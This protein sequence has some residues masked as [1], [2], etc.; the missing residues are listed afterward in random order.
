MALALDFGRTTGAQ[1][2]CAFALQLSE[3]IHVLDNEATLQVVLNS[4]SLAEF[5]RHNLSEE[6]ASEMTSLEGQITAGAIQ[7]LQTQDGIIWK[8]N[9]AKTFTVKSA[10][11][12]YMNMPTIKHTINRIWKFKVPPRFKVFA[13]YGQNDA[14]CF[15]QFVIWIERCT[16]T[17]TEEKCNLLQLADQ[18]ETQWRYS[19]LTSA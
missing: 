7:L 12:A 18:V 1:V 14:I 8:W 10:C 6:A 11:Q 5:F 9:S 13:W 19:S 4:N 2:Y 17:F 16:R 3:L 15:T